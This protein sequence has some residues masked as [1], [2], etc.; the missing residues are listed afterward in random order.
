MEKCSECG[1]PLDNNRCTYCGATYSIPVQAISIQPEFPVSQQPVAVTQPMDQNQSRNNQVPIYVTPKSKIATLL[2]CIF[3]G[4]LG[5]HKFYLKRNVMGI[6]YLVTVGLF[7]F[8][9][10][11]DIFLILFSKVTDSHGVAIQ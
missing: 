9:W 11:L 4:Y 7:G 1:A 10:I 2:L 6:I 3:F 8:G 5:A